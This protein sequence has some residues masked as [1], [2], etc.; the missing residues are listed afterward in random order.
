MATMF[1]NVTIV[2]SIQ[3]I[4][5]MLANCDDYDYFNCDFNNDKDDD[6]DVVPDAADVKTSILK[7]EDASKEVT[8]KDAD[9]AESD[10]N[11]TS[12]VAAVAP[13]VTSSEVK[14]T[15]SEQSDKPVETEKTGE[16]S[17]K[18]VEAE[19]TGEQSNK[20]VETEKTGEQSNKP[21]ETEKPGAKTEDTKPTAPSLMSINVKPPNLMSCLKYQ[22][23][24][25]KPVSLGS[26][27]L[28]NVTDILKQ[29]EKLLAGTKL[30][31]KSEPAAADTTKI[32][33]K[34]DEVDSTSSEANTGPEANTGSE[35]NVDHSE[36]DKKVDGNEENKTV[37]QC[38]A[39]NMKDSNEDKSSGRGILSPP[40]LMS[41]SVFP[42][43]HQ[44]KF[45]ANPVIASHFNMQFR[46]QLN[47]KVGTPTAGAESSSVGPTVCSG[48]TSSTTQSRVRPLFS[49]TQTS[50]KLA[51][52]KKGNPET[53]DSKKASLGTSGFKSKL[54]NSQGAVRPANT[55]AAKSIPSLLTLGAPSGTVSH[56]KPVPSLL[57]LT[58]PTI[59][60][61]LPNVRPLLG[62]SS[63]P[64]VP[65]RN[66]GFAFKHGPGDH[67]GRG[68]V[69]E[70]FDQG[71]GLFNV[72]PRATVPIRPRSFAPSQDQVEECKGVMRNNNVERAFDQT[73][74]RKTGFPVVK[75]LIRPSSQV[76]GNLRGPR[77]SGFSVSGFRARLQTPNSTMAFTGRQEV[78]NRTVAGARSTMREKSQFSVG[79][80]IRDSNSGF[81][82]NSGNWGFS[83][84]QYDSAAGY[85]GSQ[86]TQQ[87][88]QSQV[89][90]M[91]PQVS[92][93]SSRGKSAM[94]RNLMFDDRKT[95][96]STNYQRPQLVRTTTIHFSLSVC[97]LLHNLLTV[98]FCQQIEKLFCKLLPN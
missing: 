34:A 65:K 63:G 20:P 97:K 84:G 79:A 8:K 53:V 32:K 26:L 54:D 68:F 83:G 52:Q 45:T 89:F 69:G 10:D 62:F 49:A 4:Q 21:V 56:S 9:M 3:L 75:P 47:F 74:A 90:G 46:Q 42:L 73:F 70:N 38:D 48:I 19:K 93:D 50:H 94:S 95:E 11:Q 77:E 92:Q 41:L 91:R 81:G 82:A 43:H 86:D 24:V 15:D 18:P 85:R 29:L 5:T 67:N 17:N 44:R 51:S 35:A 30:P 87:K 12:G 33:Q 25:G 98:E 55:V 40:P 78:E 2:Q 1:R 58:G 76:E 60:G 6:N 31:V 80:N 27:D 72:P 37:K 57:S 36:A 14:F 66:V 96:L 22:G 61:R 28:P 71:E 59:P 16:Q 88:P 13:A 64:A 7:G 39:A 23:N